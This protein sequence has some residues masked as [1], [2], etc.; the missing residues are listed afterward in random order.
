[1]KGPKNKKEA[2]SNKIGKLRSEGYKPKQAVAIAFNM[3]DEKKKCLCMTSNVLTGVGTTVIFMCLCQ[4]TVR[5]LALI[6]TR[7]WRR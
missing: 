6:V 4:S 7:L 1:M 3:T 2:L 5:R